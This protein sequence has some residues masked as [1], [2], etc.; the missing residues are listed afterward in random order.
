MSFDEIINKME[1]AVDYIDLYDA[2]AY[3]V[4]DDLRVEVEQ[5]IEQCE[6]DNDSVE[7]A[8]SIVTSDLLDTHIFELN[9][10]LD[11]DK[12][13]VCNSIQ[14]Y[15][16]ELENASND[17]DL[18]NILDDMEENKQ[19]DSICVEDIRKLFRNNRFMPLNNKVDT[20]I[21]YINEVCLK[22]E[23]LTEATVIDNE[24][25]SFDKNKTDIEPIDND[26]KQ[27][28]EI[29]NK[30]VQDNETNNDKSQDEVVKALNDRNG[31]QFSVADL[32]KLLQNLL[33][34]SNKIFLLASD[35][36]SMNLDQTQ[37]LNVVDDNKTYVISYDIIDME[38]GIVELIDTKVESG[39]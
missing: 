32:N 26:E 18:L 39:E 17:K 16:S 9:E 33:G 20:L 7:E 27:D 35:L 11:K 14:D 36:S 13:I 30:E 34:Q 28:E 21:K 24:K 1:N 3:I 38:N 5:L 12:D 2:A 22:Q 19:L 23:H 10:S 4:D 37:K 15:I 8:Y 31:Q 6:L 29:Q 25:H